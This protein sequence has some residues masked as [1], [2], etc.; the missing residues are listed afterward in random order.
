[1]TGMPSCSARR[2]KRYVKL[3]IAVVAR[4][5]SASNSASDAI[6]FG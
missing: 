6:S 3:S 1:M 5:K 4:I 2:A